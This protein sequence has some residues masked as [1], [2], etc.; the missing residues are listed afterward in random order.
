MSA[1][2][3]HSPAVSKWPWAGGGGEGRRV[4][5]TKMNQPMGALVGVTI[6]GED[7]Q[8]RNKLLSS[9]E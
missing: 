7:R 1:P 4:G 5:N 3:P 2:H 9:G 6:S 8:K